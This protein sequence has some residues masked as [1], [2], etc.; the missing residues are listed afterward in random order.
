MLKKRTLMLIL[1]YILY[2]FFVHLH[3]ELE[4]YQ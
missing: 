4:H 2:C 1:Q 3:I